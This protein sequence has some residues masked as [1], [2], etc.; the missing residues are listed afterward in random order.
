MALLTS[1]FQHFALMWGANPHPSLSAPI[2]SHPASTDPRNI[3]GWKGPPGTI[4]SNSSGNSTTELSPGLEQLRGCPQTQHSCQTG[5]NPLQVLL[6]LGRADPQEM[7]RL[8]LGFEAPQQEYSSLS[9]GRL[10]LW[11][12]RRWRIFQTYRMQI[13][14]FPLKYELCSVPNWLGSSLIWALQRGN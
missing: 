11:H 6:K 12:G 8:L 13:K 1:H 10:E 4:E 3:W 14:W 7:W 2:H 5:T 9:K